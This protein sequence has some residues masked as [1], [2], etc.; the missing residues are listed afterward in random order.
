MARKPRRPSK[1]RQAV[2]P[3]AKVPD[4][5]WDAGIGVLLIVAVTVTFAPAVGL[6]FLHFDDDEYV[7]QNRRVTDGLTV[8]GV[9]WAFTHSH[10]RNW[11]PL[12]TLSHMLDCQVRG[13]EP[14]WHHLVNVALHGIAAVLLF[15]L[16]RRMTRL[17]WRSAMVA[18]LFAVHPLRVESVAWVSERK[19]ILSSIFFFLTLAAYDRYATRKLSMVRYLGVVLL[20]ALALMCKPMVVTLPIVLLLMDYWPLGRVRSSSKAGVAAI[21]GNEKVRKS[22]DN[23]SEMR[24]LKSESPGSPPSS[25]SPL[26]AIFLLLEKLPLLAMSIAS[27]IV[28]LIVQ[29]EAVRRNETIPL[30]QRVLNAVVSYVAYIGKTLWPSNLAALYPF[31]RDAI[32]LVEVSAA[33]VLLLAI[34]IATMRLRRQ[35]PYLLVG[36][37]WYL[38]MLV[39]VIGLVQVGRQAM[40]DRYSYLPQI[41]LWIMIV[42]LAAD[43]LALRPWLRPA[44]IGA[45]AVVLAL[46]IV[47]AWRQTLLW[48][49]DVTL[50]QRALACN[51]ANPLAHGNLSAALVDLGQSDEAVLHAQRALDLDGDDAIARYNFGN[52]LICKGRIDDALPHCLRAVEL[53]P[54]DSRFR[55]VLGNAWAWKKEYAKAI[56]QY[57]QAIRLQP[58]RADFYNNLAVSQQAANRGDDAIL[59]WQRVVDLQFDNAEPHDNLARALYLHGRTGEALVQWREAIRIQPRDPR[60]SMVAAWILATNFDPTVRN[61][62]EAVVLA[63]QARALA[64]DSDPR[65]FDTLAAAYAEAGRFH[66]AVVAAERAAALAKARDDTGLA[67]TVQAQLELYRA[68]KAYHEGDARKGF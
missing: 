10:A 38:V 14:S 40:A 7:F 37:L 11:H 53:D 52:A 25:H 49:D 15:F 50:W 4:W 45:A 31:P 13:I 64:G 16:M 58:N 56:E 17:R 35:Q 66:E 46:F 26:P 30:G 20:F 21:G 54:D 23:K 2:I 36:W 55:F 9:G 57:Q 8:E 59:S 61:G 68:G 6:P 3:A 63:E 44:M 65:V 41:G 67:A 12:T 29:Q 28:T 62:P 48:R 1:S 27:S 39:P 60:L 47:G 43:M 19:D 5:I 22:A 32:P 24:D 34:S 42:W 33:L 18:A 51:E